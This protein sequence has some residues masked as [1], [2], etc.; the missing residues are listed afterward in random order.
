MDLGK[1][2]KKNYVGSDN[3]CFSVK[4]KLKMGRELGE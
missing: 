2:I 4:K 1:E 3:K